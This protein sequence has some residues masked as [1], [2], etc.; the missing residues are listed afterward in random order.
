MKKDLKVINLFKLKNYIIVLFIILL[1]T[2]CSSKNDSVKS[3]IKVNYFAENV[4]IKKTENQPIKIYFDA[5]NVTTYHNQILMHVGKKLKEKPNKFEL[6]KE[7]KLIQKYKLTKTVG[8]IRKGYEYNYCSLFCKDVTVNPNQ[9]EIGKDYIIIN[10]LKNEKE[11]I[12]VYERIM[13]DFHQFENTNDKI[14]NK[15]AIENF[16]QMDYDEI[17][18]GKLKIYS[19]ENLQLN[20]ENFD[21]TFKNIDEKHKRGIV[22]TKNINDADYIVLINHL[23]Q[24]KFNLYKRY[25]KI[26][27]YKNEISSDNIPSIS[28]MTTGLNALSSNNTTVGAASLA[29]GAISLFSSSPNTRGNTTSYYYSVFDRKT[30]TSVGS[31]ATVTNRLDDYEITKRFYSY[32]YFEEYQKKLNKY[33]VI[34]MLYRFNILDK[35]LK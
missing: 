11:I 24:G 30:M 22:Q 20:Q 13:F 32:E 27:N 35:D 10:G 9:I 14:R 8:R 29:L 18:N 34:G 25:I 6:A 1:T 28:L 19:V 5:T 12:S 7:A 15:F 4:N 31:F 3:Q 2:G 26:P 17:K 33:S 16:I 23:G 21:Y